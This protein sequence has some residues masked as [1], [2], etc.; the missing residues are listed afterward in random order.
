MAFITGISSP[1]GGGKTAVTRRTCE[2]LPGGVMVCF[3]DYGQDIVDPD[4]YRTWLERGAD[5]NEWKTP[6]L[7]DDLAR[8]K[9]GQAV[10]YPANGALL[11]PAKQ[12][13]F[14][15]PLG[16]AH[17]ETGKLIDLM[18]YIDTPLDIAM[19]RRLT[20]DYSP[21]SDDPEGALDAISVELR[22]YLDYGRL[23]YLEMDKQVKPT[24][25]LV[26]D[27][28]QSIDRIAQEIAQAIELQVT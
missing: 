12:V 23:A 28:C 15:A 14:D 10:V 19:A 13:V 5:Y 6:T 8:L 4:C 7:A 21:S 11:G 26:V 18:V 22:S 3:D 1:S 2:L 16:R 25:D 17:A 24:S 9:A 20:R 27:G